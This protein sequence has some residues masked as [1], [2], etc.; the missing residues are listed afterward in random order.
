RTEAAGWLHPA[1]TVRDADPARDATGCAAIYGPFVSETAISFE[2]RIPTAADFAARIH[3]IQQ[4]HPWLV[5]EQDTRV[6]GFAYGCPH[7]ERAAYRFAAEVSVYIDPVFHHRGIGRGLYS[8]LLGLLREQGLWIACAGIGLPNEAS[9]ALHESLGFVPVGVYRKI[10]YKFGQWWDVGWWQ[11]A[12][13]EP[14]EGPPPEPGR[15]VR[16]DRSRPPEAGV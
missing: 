11:L 15:P 13:R 1:M 8:A 12:L 16:V 7:R 5:A 9:V 3:R 6:V 14:G 2:E 10:G 4:T